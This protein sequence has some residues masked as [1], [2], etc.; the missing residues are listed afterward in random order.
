MELAET[1]MARARTH[2]RTAADHERAGKIAAADNAGRLAVDCIAAAQQLDEI[3]HA[4]RHLL[5]VTP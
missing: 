5:E 4:S 2:L 3:E 1:L